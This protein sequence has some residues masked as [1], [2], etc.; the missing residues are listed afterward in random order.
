[1]L[2]DDG[3]RRLVVHV[4]VARRIAQLA[5]SRLDGVTV[6]GEDGARQAVRRRAIADVERLL[7]LRVVIDVDRDHRAEDFFGHRLEGRV[8]RLD[9]R[10]LDE[11]TRRLVALAAEEDLCVGRLTSVVDVAHDVVERSL[12]DHGVDEV[13]EVLH[14]A[15]LDLLQH[16]AHALL[17]LFPQRLG[18]VGTRSG[19]ALLALI[20][21][22][23]AHDG[24]CHIFSRSRGM[25]EDEVLATRLT[26]HLGI[27]LVLLQVLAH[28]TPERVEG[29]RGTGEVEAC[30]VGAG[31]DHAPNRAALAGD[32]VHHAV[33]QTGL[34]EDLHEQVVRID[35]RRRGF[36]HGHVTHHS[37]R[38]VE[39]RGDRGEVERRQR[40][41]EALQGAILQAVDDAL[42]RIGLVGIDLPGVEGAVTQEVDQLARGV[43]L[44]LEGV[45]ALAEHHG[46]V[47]Q[48]AILRGEK[49]SRTQHHHRALLPRQRRPV[50]VCLHGCV[51]SHLH[52]LFARLVVGRQHMAVVMRHHYLVRLTRAD[53]LAADHQRDVPFFSAQLQ[54]S[55]LQGRFI[56]RAGSIRL[57]RLISRIR[58]SVNRIVHKSVSSLV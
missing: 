47:E 9:H 30:K 23:A 29:V 28:L 13:R 53:L 33:R 44:G 7:I 40:K 54:Q 4:E 5:E 58:E 39:V 8:R 15:H 26:H 45:L 12:V 37:R 42:L 46:G 17:D 34:F 20:L 11:V 41:D 10:R 43:N 25:G 49:F 48:V 51:D 24:C 21:E 18:Q 36:P 52:F 19:G 1:M 27:R 57:D 16:L 38:H 56:T 35:S 22:G 50:V 3:A 55:L 6:A 14:V 2:C 31:Q 32:E